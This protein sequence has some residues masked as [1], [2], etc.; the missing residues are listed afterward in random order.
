MDILNKIKWIAGVLF[1]FIIVITTN[2]I[3]KDNFNRLRYSVITIYEDRIVANDLIFEILLLIH[4]KEMAVAV[5]DSS[6]FY[7][8]NDKINRDIKDL[9]ERYEQTKL[10]NQEQ[11]IFND[12]KEG[13]TKLNSLEA[14]LTASD[15]DQEITANL[16][17]SINEIVNNLYD[18][19][20]V[21]LTEGKT[22][23]LASNKAM[24]TIDVFTQV[25][26]VF[27]ILMA[28]IILTIVLYKPKD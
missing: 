1:V 22:Q 4:E 27:L 13:F 20:K 24:D 10:T 18:L 15:A 11:K 6:F 2:L 12:L 21:Q 3:D 16:I 9:I 14:K 25:E 5:S 28:I 23:M 7:N 26:I 8:E 19:S 17:D